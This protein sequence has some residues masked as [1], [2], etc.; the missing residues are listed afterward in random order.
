MSKVKSTMKFQTFWTNRVLPGSKPQQFEVLPARPLVSLPE[1]LRAKIALKKKVLD[2]PKQHSW[3]SWQRFYLPI[4]FKL[5]ITT[6]C[7]NVFGTKK[8][9]CQSIWMIVRTGKK[10]VSALCFVA[11][12]QNLLVNLQ[13]NSHFLGYKP[14]PRPSFVV[15]NCS[16]S[17][18]SRYS[19]DWS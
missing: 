17:S 1:Q 4:F 15:I 10:V 16:C 7:W 13:F 11:E 18:F 3:D 14:H 8:T 12:P 6:R 9:S 2:A 5:L 19:P